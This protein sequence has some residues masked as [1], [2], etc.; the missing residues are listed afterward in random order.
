VSDPSEK[1]KKVKKRSLRRKLTLRKVSEM[2]KFLLEKNGGAGKEKGR[3]TSLGKR[4]TLCQEKLRVG[5]EIRR[6]VV[7][8]KGVERGRGDSNASYCERSHSPSKQLP[9][10]EG[11]RGVISKGGR[12]G[13]SDV[14]SRGPKVLKAPEGEGRRPGRI[15]RTPHPR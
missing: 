9:I 10:I 7:R 3:S 2:G 14:I 12:G 15:L 5:E 6:S 4:R 11:E 1:E 13:K 8:L